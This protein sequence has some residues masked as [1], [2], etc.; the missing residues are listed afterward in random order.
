MGF[1]SLTRNPDS[2]EFI[3]NRIVNSFG[4]AKDMQTKL[5]ATVILYLF[6]NIFGQGWQSQ[7]KR[8]FF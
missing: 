2:E 4:E 8:S 5:D 6:I 3:L 7:F 1:G